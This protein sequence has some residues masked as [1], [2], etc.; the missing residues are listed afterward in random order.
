MCVL[1]EA[2]APA[3]AI[4]LTNREARN[5]L[6]KRG[7]HRAR[8]LPDAPWWHAAYLHTDQTM[9]DAATGAG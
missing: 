3:R 9:E 8:A 4:F 6:S 7:S 1:D 2:T 5:A